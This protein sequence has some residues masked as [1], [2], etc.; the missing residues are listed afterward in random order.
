MRQ[1]GFGV[2]I[3]LDY[4]YIH[5]L[6]RALEHGYHTFRIQA[7]ILNKK[8]GHRI[9]HYKTSILLSRMHKII[10]KDERRID[11]RNHNSAVIPSTKASRLPTIRISV[12]VAA[13]TK[14]LEP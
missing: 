13:L 7:I 4:F 11:N 5:R 10:N 8:R 14:A 3:P 1:L 9:I 12:A 6:D 2:R